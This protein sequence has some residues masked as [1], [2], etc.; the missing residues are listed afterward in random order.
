LKNPLK[1]GGKK[2]LVLATNNLVKSSL[3][4]TASIAAT[5]TFIF[6]L[7]LGV[8]L[9]YKTGAYFL[10]AGFYSYSLGSG[11]APLNPE[12]IREHLGDTVFSVH[13]L[14]SPLFTMKA[15]ASISNTA[16]AFIF[17]LALQQMLI[18]VAGFLTVVGVMRS[19][20]QSQHISVYAT[21]A[22]LFLPFANL[23]LGSVLYPHPEPLG[24]ASLALAGLIW[25]LQ[26][27]S[28]AGKIK[29]VSL[30]IFAIYGFFT[31]EDMGIHLAIVLGSIWLLSES[32]MKKSLRKSKTFILLF[33]SS[34]VS[35]IIS[36]LWQKAFS[37]QGLKSFEYTYSGNPPYQ[38]LMSLEAIATRVL[39]FAST[40]LDITLLIA[41]SLIAYLITKHKAL[42][43]FPLVSAPWILINLTA[44]DP[45]KSVL[46]TYHQFPFI[47]YVAAPAIYLLVRKSNQA[48]ESSKGAEWA[49]R[50]AVAFAL[51]TLA[52]SG[53]SL[54][55]TGGGYFMSILSKYEAP[56]PAQI[57]ETHEKLK[58]IANAEPHVV[59][60]DA[61][62]TL[63]PVLFEKNP[64][65][66]DFADSKI[67][68]NVVFFPSYALGQGTIASFVGIAETQG[69]YYSVAC[70]TQ[71][72]AQIKLKTGEV[73]SLDRTMQDI[74]NCSNRN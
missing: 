48:V 14:F 30:W 71:D 19:T 18:S 32:T 23:G 11:N 35:V 46:G 44:V 47:L 50:L 15:I 16:I 7:Y 54:P 22:A 66:I 20:G 6:T 28:N 36:A 70:I 12:R 2:G 56:S 62:M 10:D 4:L 9:F 34:L 17:T 53:I 74:A 1:T 61:V 40:R 43:V 69:G 21:L 72:I 39:G 52:I 5:F 26:F 59:V 45:A 8:L 41:C 24:A 37:T 58:A 31:R 73:R 3:W 67:P 51:S 63:E 29:S 27:N 42:L 64:M 68:E 25:A 60:D 55:P 33:V 38:H 65:T 13:T 49:P 57:I